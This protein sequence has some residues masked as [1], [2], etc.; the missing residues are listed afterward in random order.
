MNGKTL[1]FRPRREEQPEEQLGDARYVNP[2]PEIPDPIVR[3]S[4]AL[5]FNQFALSMIPLTPVPF[6]GDPRSVF[7]YVRIAVYGIGSYLTFAKHRKISYVLMAATG[8]CAIT[9]FLDGAVRKDSVS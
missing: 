7:A 2:P 9:S 5:T 8:T 1:S 6:K 3:K 4:P